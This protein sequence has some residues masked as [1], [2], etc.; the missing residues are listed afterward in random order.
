MSEN[1]IP[2]DSVEPNPGLEAQISSKEQLIKQDYAEYGAILKSPEFHN[3]VVTLDSDEVSHMHKLRVEKADKEFFYRFNDGSD[4][5]KNPFYRAAYMHS[6]LKKLAS[7]D[8][9]INDDNHYIYNHLWMRSQGASLEDQLA[10]NFRHNLD[11]ANLLLR[12]IDNL[13]LEADIKRRIIEQAKTALIEGGEGERFEIRDVKSL[14]DN[15]HQV[16]NEVATEAWHLG[17]LMSGEDQE[18]ASNEVK[19]YLRTVKDTITIEVE[20]FKQQLQSINHDDDARLFDDTEAKKIGMVPFKT[21]LSKLVARYL[22]QKAHGLDNFLNNPSSVDM[23]ELSWVIGYAMKECL[24]AYKH[25][26]PLYDKAFESLDEISKEST[27]PEIYLGRDGVYAFTGRKAQQQASKWE[28]KD[29]QRQRK[30]TGKVKKIEPKYLVFPRKYMTNLSQEAQRAYLEQE[31]IS[32]DV[33]PH[34][35]DTGFKGTIPENILKLIGYEDESLGE[36]IHLISSDIDGREFADMQTIATSRGYNLRDRVI[37]VEHSPKAT[38]TSRGLYRDENGKI[39]P[40]EIAS[41]PRRQLIFETV[42]QA[43]WR[44]YWLKNLDGS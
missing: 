16:T 34:I 35:F 8:E 43:L 1:N 24:L 31:G 26:T 6:I 23:K 12:G 30:V 11:D 27:V 32:K 25:D 22:V 9:G 18:G 7:S 42:R 37:D 15:P 4:V 39:R 29:G 41:S 20:K 2:V 19:E 10:F 33:D 36:R 5:Y 38:K 13:P 17:N 21:A 40:I 44:H 14:P 3:L 28:I